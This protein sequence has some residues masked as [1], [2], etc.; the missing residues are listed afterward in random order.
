[1]AKPDFTRLFSWFDHKSVFTL[2]KKRKEMDN[3]RGLPVHLRM[4]K[5]LLT[6]SFG[7]QRVIG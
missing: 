2:L 7:R 1:M 5:M 3:N 4:G 6:M